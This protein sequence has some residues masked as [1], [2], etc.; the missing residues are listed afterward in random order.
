MVVRGVAGPMTK[1]GTKCDRNGKVFPFLDVEV[2][3]LGSGQTW[4]L[5]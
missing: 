4:A 3:G 2:P 5:C 1:T